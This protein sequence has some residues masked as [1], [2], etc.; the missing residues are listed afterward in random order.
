MTFVS[1]QKVLRFW[2]RQQPARDVS[3]TPAM[4]PNPPPLSDGEQ[5]A[6]AMRQAGIDLWLTPEHINGAARL[7]SPCR[8]AQGFGI[9]SSLDVGAFTY[10]WSFIGENVGKIG[11]YCSIAE[12]VGFGHVEHPTNW[13]S[14][15]SFTYDPGFFIDHVRRK[16]QS[17]Y[18]N[19]SL[20]RERKRSPI[21]IG[22]DVWIGHQAYIRSG[23]R[24]GTG[25]I[26]GA[27]AIVTKDVPAYAIVAGNPARIVKYRFSDDVIER[28][29]RIQWW[30]YD[31]ADFSD[32]DASDVHRACDRLE[33]LIA[34]GLPLYRP[35]VVY[36][37]GTGTREGLEIRI[38]GK[39]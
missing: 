16:G 38:E 20:P 6:D 8:F 29:Q 10:T 39:K 3:R 25:C 21:E 2:T 1:F 22:N 28:L 17:W 5:F 35:G 37:T 34:N 32:V 36:I 24:L 15:S 9:S 33:S 7:E 30:N 23:T 31:F 12:N 26:V 4:G 27:R 19:A 14:T 18:K 13:I 11:R